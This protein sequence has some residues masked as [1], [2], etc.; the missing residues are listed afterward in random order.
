MEFSK[1]FFFFANVFSHLLSD[2]GSSEIIEFRTN[3][4]YNLGIKC[5]L[6]TG[7][8]FTRFGKLK[9]YET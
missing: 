5:C 2:L 6:K 8:D 1:H 9:Y 4:K 3:K 7:I